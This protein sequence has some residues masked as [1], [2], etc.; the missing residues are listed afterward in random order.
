MNKELYIK[1]LNNQCSP[2]E[3]KTVVQWLKSGTLYNENKQWGFEN[4]EAFHDDGNSVDDEKFMD[5]FYKIQN[6]I[7]KDKER[8]PRGAKSVYIKWM[9]RAAA[10][11]FIPLLSI[12][13]Y[14]IS[15]KELGVDQFTQLRVDS[16]EVI[17]PVGS[18]TVLQLSDGTEVH[19]NFGSKLKYPRTFTGKFRE[20]T[21]IGEGYFDVAHNPEK[22]FMVK[23]GT[24]NV[25]ALGTEFNVLAYTDDDVI[26]TTLIEGKVALEKKLP[27]GQRKPLV[28]LMP[29]QHVKYN[30]KTGEINSTKGKVEKFIVWKEGKMVFD[31]TPITE[32]AR[33]L[34]R[35]YNVDIE[36]R[37]DIK[38]YYY[39][40]TFLDEPLTQILELMTIATPISYE[41]LPRKKLSDD[42]FSKQKIL[43]K[44]R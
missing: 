4:W 18:R 28:A 33:H 2:E 36:V 6:R 7:D 32:V 13:L 29:G 30:V 9:I 35:K 31:D 26:E 21:L 24:L 20:V 38:D 37:D 27:D 8:K 17:S 25:K 22:P 11:L 23:T 3:L 39:T 43:I 15:E 14:T 16:I 34:E 19:L 40:V 10:I 41:V 1:F 44:S 5:L 42:T 12:F